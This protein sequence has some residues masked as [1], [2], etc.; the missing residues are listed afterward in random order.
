MT[1]TTNYKLKKPEEADQQDIHILNENFDIID[2]ELHSRLK[3]SGWTAGKYLGTDESGNVI[4]KDAAAATEI[5]D[6]AFVQSE[7]SVVATLTQMDGSI[8][9]IT[10]AFGEN[11]FP[12]KISTVDRSINLTWEGF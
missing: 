10:I 8:E 2:T 7:T 3:S 4:V 11:G 9:G 5:T 6:I 1:E 12:S